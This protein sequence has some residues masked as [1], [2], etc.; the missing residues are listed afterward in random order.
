MKIGE[1]DS[2]AFPSDL[3]SEI[4]QYVPGSFYIIG[5]HQY[6]L[7]K[8]YSLPA[9][10]R[11]QVL[12]IKIRAIPNNPSF[13]E[14]SVS[15]I[16]KFVFYA[17][18]VGKL[19]YRG[20]DEALQQKIILRRLRIWHPRDLDSIVREYDFYFVGHSPRILQ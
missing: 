8:E 7:L 14:T 10:R 2:L 12:L 13:Y 4:H 3:E 16:G 15:G 11:E 1:T 18:R 20:N 17:E 9:I 19:T 5:D 6:D